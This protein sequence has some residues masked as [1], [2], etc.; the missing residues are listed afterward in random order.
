MNLAAGCC[1]RGAQ[2]CAMFAEAFADRQRR[3]RRAELQT[4]TEMHRI[5]VGS[6]IRFFS[7]TVFKGLPMAMSETKDGGRRWSFSIFPDLTTKN[8]EKELMGH[9]GSEGNEPHED[10]NTYYDWWTNV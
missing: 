2:I 4:L 5:V 10:F 9:R 7:I 1:P 8:E 6:R 3:Q